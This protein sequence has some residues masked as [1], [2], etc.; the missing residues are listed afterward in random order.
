MERDCSMAE[1]KSLL[2]QIREKEL[3]MSVKVDQA[4]TEADITLEQA[5]KE[6]LAL[7]M[8]SEAEGKK[9]AHEFFLREMEHIE[10]EAD[11]VQAVAKEE[12]KFVR[13]KGEKNLPQ[14]VERVVTIVLSG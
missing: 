2:K 9:A 1:D 4:R 3:E 12:V 13:E 14:A 8:T 5:K 11:H 7:I 10:A 6:S